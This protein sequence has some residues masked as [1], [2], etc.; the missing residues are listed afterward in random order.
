MSVTTKFKKHINILRGTAEGQ[1]A[2][3]H[4]YPK[5]YRKVAKFY[6]E[7]SVFN[8]RMTLAMIMKSC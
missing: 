2:L 5:Y 1:I 3:D 8:L 7:R 4:Q 6:M